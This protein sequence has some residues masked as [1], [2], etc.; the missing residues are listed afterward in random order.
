MDAVGVLGQAVDEHLD[1]RELVDAVEALGELA[2]GS[3]LAAEAV[4][5]AGEAQGEV[6]WS[7]TAPE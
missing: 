5:E 1:L 3:G 4:R 7:M 2:R 6:A